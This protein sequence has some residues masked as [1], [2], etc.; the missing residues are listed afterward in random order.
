MKRTAF[1][2]V[3]RVRDPSKP[4]VSVRLYISSASSRFTPSSTHTVRPV[5]VERSS[6]N[7]WSNGWWLLIQRRI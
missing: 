5:E 3:L 6:V 4:V 2:I 7:Y 1:W